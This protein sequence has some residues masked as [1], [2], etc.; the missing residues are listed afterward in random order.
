[1]AGS[2]DFTGQN[3]QDT[4]Q[5]VLQVSS[6]GQVTD[7][8]GSVVNVSNIN[9]DAEFNE[10]LVNGAAQFYEPV[11]FVDGITMQGNLTVTGSLSAVGTVTAINIVNTTNTTSGLRFNPSSTDVL[12]NLIVTG[13]ITASGNISSSGTIKANVFEGSLTG[14]ATGLSGTP[15]I[16]VGSLTA[17]SI[18]SSIV[19]SSII[20]TEGSNIFGD[21]IDDTQLFNGHITASGNISASGDVISTNIHATGNITASGNIS[22][23]FG[24]FTTL[25]KGQQSTFVFYDDVPADGQIP[26]FANTSGTI[27]GSD[28]FKINNGTL[29]FAPQ[30]H[31]GG[32]IIASGQGSII[33][34]NSNVTSTGNISAVG[35]ISASGNLYGTKV[36]V[37]ENGV[38]FPGSNN[39]IYY[40]GS[41]IN[42][43][44]DDAD[45]LATTSTGINVS[46]DIKTT[47]HITASGNISSS[48]DIFADDITAADLISA[49]RLTVD[50]LNLNSNTISSTTD[51]DV[52]MVLAN[53][54]ISFEANAGDKFL[55]NTV[56]NNVD[57]QVSGENDQNLIYG[58]ASEDKV[59]IGTA[60]PT[61]KL[62][63]AGNIN[64]TSHITAS[65]IISA[66]GTI[67]ANS[68]IGNGLSIDGPSNAHIEVG[69]YPVGY[70]FLNLPGSGLVITGSGLIIS[71]AMADANH[72][73]MLK[74]G[75]VELI[76]LNTSVSQNE[77]LI[78]NRH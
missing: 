27:Q 56:Q 46:G 48:G 71:G 39:T 7:G 6:S 59:G 32:L 15:D 44:I 50:T 16:I 4:Y 61:A 9:A 35:N 58:D 60:T 33:E 29:V 37:G 73:N 64:A 43:M 66:S 31:S 65:G 23:S 24:Q 55:F 20:Y 13:S 69:E 74:I 63:V 52:Y 36:Y 18:T 53:D 14:T 19:T 10:L 72:H 75:N 68:F 51:G 54:G 21:A 77:F 47:S 40:D 76:D 2:N 22:A 34:L 41:N 42:I 12:S 70:D 17:T 57:L 62:D 3:I 38:E 45:I 25:K 11:V 30:G 1:M 5:R 26:L 49:G 67:T 78:H 28:Q 8:T